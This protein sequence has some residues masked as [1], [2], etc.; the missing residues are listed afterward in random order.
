MHNFTQ[1][2]TKKSTQSL[3]IST[4]LNSFRITEVSRIGISRIGLA[5]LSLGMFINF[6]YADIPV[7]SVPLSQPAAPVVSTE[8][9]QT[10]QLWILTQKVQKL[11][12][13]VRNLRGKVESHDNDID[14]LQKD[15]KNHFIDFDQRLGQV[16]DDL[17]K[18]QTG[19]G[20]PPST[21]SSNNIPPTNTASPNTAP[22]NA[23]VANNTTAPADEADKVAYIAAYEAYKAGG[24]A[25]AIAPMKKFIAD[26]PQSQFVPNAYYWL[27]EFNLA[28]TPPNFGLASTNFKVVTN[29]YPKSAKAAASFYRLATLADVDKHQTTAIALMKTL[30]KD[31]PG[32]Q[33]DGFETDYLKSHTASSAN[34]TEKSDKKASKKDELTEKHKRSAKKVKDSDNNDNT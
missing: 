8:S 30:Q 29:K 16:Q 27:G 11:E 1:H 18:S 22:Q 2:N 17:K 7:E 34:K 19:A 32:T 31:Y 5:S 9:N 15:T 24:A 20:Q 10:S 13:D 6:A 26:Y 23:S 28:V 25:Q 21:D 14:Q 33:E 4:R 12:E 3:Q